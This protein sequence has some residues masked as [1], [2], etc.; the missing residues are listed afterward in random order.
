VP[1]SPGL[2]GLS[3]VILNRMSTPTSTPSPQDQPSQMATPTGQ[4]CA[5]SS[6]PSG[7]SPADAE[8]TA[9]DSDYADPSTRRRLVPLLLFLATCLSTFWVA[10]AEF[11]P[12]A[13]LQNMQSGFA[14]VATNWQ[15]GV[16][17][18]AA[19][20]AILLTHEMGHFLFTLRFKISASY[21]IFIPV[22][23]N[24]IGTM[25][26]VIGMDGSKAN[27]RQLYDL[28]LAGPVAG[29]IVAIPVLAMGV[30]QLDLT[31]PARGMQFY[32]PLMVE[33]LFQYLRPGEPMPE[34][35]AVSQLNPLFMAGWVGLLVTGLNM[36]P[37]SQLDGGHVA[38]AVFGRRAH[39]IA[40]IFLICAIA[41]IIIER[42]HI[43]MLM[44]VLVI[45]MG[46]DHPPT[47]DDSVELN[48][49]RW[50]LG[51]LALAI[52]IICFPY[53]GISI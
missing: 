17:Y 5:N 49:A 6:A 50:R 31:I 53:R 20:L 18:M 25:G 9:D 36:L 2:N 33:W 12:M 52:P 42:I 27:R 44:L 21:P 37:I 13:A 35:I 47:S 28:A 3:P 19:V 14:Q 45:I 23:F 11:R 34:A 40:R 16:T 22:P 7:D 4:V 43:W 48:E 51:V 10:A 15:Q 24:P 29:L 41:F 32:N 30:K 8:T 26:A 38:Y 39:T 1:E 46:V